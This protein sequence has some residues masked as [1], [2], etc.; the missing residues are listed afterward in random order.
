MEIDSKLLIFYFMF[1][2]FEILYIFQRPS[3]INFFMMPPNLD[4]SN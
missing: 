1:C 3:H 4:I 2:Y